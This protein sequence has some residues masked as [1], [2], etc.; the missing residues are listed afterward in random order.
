VS[1]QVEAADAE[2]HVAPLEFPPSARGDPKAAWEA[3]E[4]IV[5]SLERTTL[6]TQRQGYLHAE[7]ASALLGFVDDLEC[8]LD[9]AGRVIQARSASRVG[10]SD[11]GVNRKRVE[12]LR[13]L[14]A[15]A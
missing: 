11:L 2:H 1:S 6:V 9:A 4:R 12:R 15:Q 13:E 5:R 10:H 3:L 8:L 14:L 7:V